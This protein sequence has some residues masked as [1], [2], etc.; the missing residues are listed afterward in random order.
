MVLFSITVDLMQQIF[1]HGD[2][3]AL[4]F[5]FEFGKI[6]IYQEPD[7]SLIFGVSS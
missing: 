4:R 2:I 1:R 6:N 7:P 5:N 3:N